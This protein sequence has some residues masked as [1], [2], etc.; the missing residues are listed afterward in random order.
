MAN[1][2]I[3]AV[4][5]S[6]VEQNKPFSAKTGEVIG[7]EKGA[8]MVKNY[9]DKTRNTESHFIG[10]DMIESILA[11]PGAEGI[12]VLYGVD[13]KGAQKPVLVGVNAE[14]NFILNFTTVDATGELSKQRGVITMGGVRSGGTQPCGWFD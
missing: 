11:Q 5:E 6:V 14:G 13:E 1:T 9:Y 4:K 10:R 7:Y 8:K 3:C 2:E 12:T